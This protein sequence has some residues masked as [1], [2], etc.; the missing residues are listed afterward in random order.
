MAPVDESS[1]GYF[2][3]DESVET[4]PQASEDAKKEILGDVELLSEDQKSSML[5]LKE[6]AK[7]NTMKL[8]RVTGQ[9]SK[10]E[11]GREFG[12]KTKW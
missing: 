6:P 11:K 3:E 5:A 9:D 10:P 7:Y 4:G 8:K 1:R 12:L 2:I